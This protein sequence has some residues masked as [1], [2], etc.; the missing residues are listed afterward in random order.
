MKK[1]DYSG[2]HSAPALHISVRK[3]QCWPEFFITVGLLLAASSQLLAQ[4]FVSGNLAVVRVGDG[5]QALVSSGNT[6]FVDQFTISGQLVS[7]VTVPDT[8]GE[9]LILSGTA[10]SEGQLTRSLD[11]LVLAIAGYHTN[12]GTVTGSLASQ[13]AAAVPRAIGTITISGFYQLAQTST[14]V[15][16]GNNIRGAVT[17]GTNNFWTAGSPGGTYYFNPPQIPVN[18]QTNGGN[19]R[20]IKIFGNALYYSTQAGTAGVYRFLGEGLPTTGQ[21]TDLL[22]ATGT[23]SQ[24]ASFALNPALTVAY[25]ADQRPN[26]GGIQKWTY[27]GALWSLAYNIPTGGGAVGLTADFN[28]ATPIVYATT[29]EGSSNRLVRLVDTGPAVSLELLAVAGSNRAFRGVDFAPGTSVP[30]RLAIQV[31][32]TNA[33]FTWPVAATGY[34]L[35]NNPDLTQTTDWAIVSNP[36]VVVNGSNTVTVPVT[37]GREFYRLVQ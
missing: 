19:T 37:A 20:I 23:N 1:C 5:A 4:S 28:S 12:R 21:G 3:R 22:F 11:G 36:V 29:A 10:G 18:V 33:V 13:S 17:D 24:P 32:G 2:R 7:T 6:V 9:A 8:A 27:D 15:Y 25:V 14:F 30:V 35:Q 16:S 26:A 31:S 34:S